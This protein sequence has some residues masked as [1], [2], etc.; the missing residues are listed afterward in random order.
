MMRDL[1]GPAERAEPVRQLLRAATNRAGR[2]EGRDPRTTEARPLHDR[3][4]RARA[5]DRARRGTS[6]RDDADR[7]AGALRR[8]ARTD[9]PDRSRARRRQALPRT[10]AH[11]LEQFGLVL[12]RSHQIARRC[13]RAGSQR[14]GDRAEIADRVLPRLQQISGISHPQSSPWTPSPRPAGCGPARVAM[15]LTA[16]TERVGPQ[17]GVS[18]ELRRCASRIR[19]GRRDH[20]PGSVS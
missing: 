6:A 4:G 3:R 7:P 18:V 1:F 17:P 13:G 2:L 10:R 20:L 11:L 16:I 14:G 9:P 12:Q 8:H 19:C 5:A 15:S